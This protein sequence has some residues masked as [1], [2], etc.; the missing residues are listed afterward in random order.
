MKTPRTFTPKAERALHTAACSL[1][2][3]GLAVGF[4]VDLWLGMAITMPFVLVIVVILQLNH[5]H[6]RRLAVEEFMTQASSMPPNERFREL[7]R[8]EKKYGKYSLRVVRLRR[9][10][11]KL[12]D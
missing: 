8:I 3:V 9:I 10:L 11:E 2:G 12:D 4:L 1:A 6:D 5:N 7:H